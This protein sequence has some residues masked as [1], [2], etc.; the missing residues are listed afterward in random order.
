MLPK[1][2]NPRV[3]YTIL[4]ACFI[5]FGTLMA[6]R[7]AKGGYRYT[8]QGFIKESGLLSANSFPTGAEVYINDKLVTATNDTVYLEPGDYQV[9]I[10]KDGFWP[11]TKNLNIEKELVVQ[12]NAQLFPIAPS[13][14]PLTFSGVDRVMPSPDGQKILYTTSTASSNAKSGLYVLE[15]TDSFLAL[16]RGSRQI[17]P[18]PK[19]FSLKNADF[20]WSPDSNEVMILTPGRQI[21]LDLNDS[22]NL[23]LATDITFRRRQILSEWEAEMYL[24]ERQYLKEFPDEI[25]EIATSSAQNVYFSPDKKRL[26]YT[27]TK[28]L[29]IPEGIAP[30]VPSPNSQAQSRNLVAGERYVYDREEDTNFYI[31]TEPVISQPSDSEG[32]TETPTPSPMPQKLML[33]TDLYQRSALT[34]AASPSAFRKLQEPTLADTARSF[35][36]YHSGLDLDQLQWF[37]DSKHMLYT[38]DGSIQIKGYDN[39]NDTT[40]YSGPY[41]KDFVYPWPDGS[42]LLI[43]TTFN[44]DTPQNLYAISLE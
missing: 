33:A 23:D 24:R 11:W 16:Q 31:G 15:L 4:S 13:L 19:S 12:T 35:W 40:V 34:L 2:V 8:N 41:T 6:I 3:L 28:A 18:P 30:P 39:T 17:S 5:F 25:V 38:T 26:L 43:L 21:L 14:T 32:D 36:K 44:P 22:Q 20:I 27:A 42:K 7:Y 9:K 29:V 1:W 10:I 37:S